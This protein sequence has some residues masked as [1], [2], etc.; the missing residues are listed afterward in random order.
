MR[1]SP[2]SLTVAAM[3]GRCRRILVRLPL[4]LLPLGLLPLA[5]LSLAVLAPARAGEF[6]QLPPAQGMALTLP[7]PGMANSTV[8]EPSVTPVPPQIDPDAGRRRLRM[9]GTGFPSIGGQ[10]PNQRTGS[11]HEHVVRD[12]CIG[13]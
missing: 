7:E 13:C 3:R 11:R 9:L 2:P 5:S 1:R 6:A 12:I 10:L 4:G 8:A